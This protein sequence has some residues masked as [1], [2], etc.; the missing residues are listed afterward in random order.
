MIAS[1][2]EELL[3]WLEATPSR[4]SAGSTIRSMQSVD[5]IFE[6]ARTRG[7]R[8]IAGKVLMNRNTPQDLRDTPE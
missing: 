7:V 6:S 8:L 1:H 2:R 4:P 3:D 5:A